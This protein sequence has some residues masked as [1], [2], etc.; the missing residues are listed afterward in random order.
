MSGAAAQRSRLALLALL[1]SAGTVGI[2]RDKLLVYLWAESDTERARHA[3]KQAV[4]SLRRDLGSDDAIVGTATLC[5]NASVVESDL[6]DFELAVARGDDAAAVA[7]YTGPFLDGVFLKDAP[8]FERWAADERAR[9]AHHW[10]NAV[11]RLATRSEAEGDWRAAISF[12]RQLAAA[13]PMSGRVT[14]AL[15]RSLAESGD[16]AAALQHY[17]VH[18][19]LVRE[20]LD[21]APES[22]VSSLA[23]A[24]RA[25]TWQRSVAVVRPSPPSVTAVATVVEG[26]TSPTREAPGTVVAPAARFRRWPV[27][28]AALTLIVIV[29]TLLYA[30]VPE[31]TRSI[32][33]TMLT[34][35]PGAITPGLYV[36]AP[37]ENLTGDTTLNMFGDL[38]AE[39]VIEALRRANVAVVSAKTASATKQIIDRMPSVVRPHERGLAVASEIGANTAVVGSYYK[40]GDTLRVTL[41]FIDMA[42]RREGASFPPIEGVVKGTVGS[43]PLAERLG[44]A[45]LARVA[46]A[47]DTTAE[48]RTLALVPAS[49]YE[50]YTYV[51]RAYGRFFQDPADTAG[52]FSL[53]G[54]ALKI[55]PDYVAPLLVRAYILDVKRIWP[56]AEETVRKIRPHARSLN[57]VE[58]EWLELFESDLRGDPYGRLRAARRSMQ[59]SPMSTEMALAVVLSALYVGR[60]EEALAALKT[61]DPNRGINLISPVYWQ[62]RA[63]A[64]HEGEKYAAEE[65]SAKSGMERFASA[66]PSIQTMARVLATAGRTQALHDLLSAGLP[67]DSNPRA[68]KIELSLA[69]A[70][71]LRHHGHAA[72]ADSMLRALADEQRSTPV[73]ASPMER[74]FQATVLYDLGRYAEAKVVLTALAQADPSDL[75]AK[76]R[77]GAIAVRTGDNTTAARI[78]S[79]LA[80]VPQAYFIGEANTWRA[81]LAAAGGRIDDAV[82]L[83]RAAVKRGYRLMDIAPGTVHLD[84]DFVELSASPAYAELKRELARAAVP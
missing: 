56:A 51:T 80:A 81:H 55:D 12:R 39:T 5:L 72:A 9:L 46:Q 22:D 8:E 29:G 4:Y 49:S 57:A 50:A 53:L 35:G 62:W 70:Q 37:L 79:E 47:A 27:A 69:S 45:T 6:R 26:P 65:I 76:G 21:A 63:E 3:L 25:G 17:R 59:L 61:S 54:E 64:E 15:M 84:R 71:E 23:D 2:S 67:T 19:M 11:E 20:E 48:G 75:A 32:A 68:G 74:N 40:N 34:R 13:E 78:D 16:V 31:R 58:H 38:A 60:P 24:M 33:R 41:Q 30:R 7:V 42:T 10:S 83:L 44:R 14:L 43:I 28:I 52:V 18:E 77:L 1:A 73:S 82:M 66:T 36:V